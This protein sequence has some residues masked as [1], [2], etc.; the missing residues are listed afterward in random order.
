ML[1]LLD[2]Y[3]SFTWN[4]VHLLGTLSPDLDIAVHRN[5][6]LTIEAIETL[7]PQ[8]I[9]ISPGPCTP[10]ETGICR[11][12]IRTF[13]GCIPLLGV[14]LGHQSI[15]DVHGATVRRSDAPVH[16]RTSTINHTG[17]GVFAALPPQLEVARYHSLI[18]D[19]E[20]IKP[21]LEVT[22][23]TDDGVVMALRHTEMSAPLVGV[24]FHPES[25]LTPCG[26]AL[27]AN[28]LSIAGISVDASAIPCDA[29]ET[30]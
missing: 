18:V 20:A 30:N 10:S 8:A 1:L 6:A 23:W 4:L 9:V 3:D 25:F 29:S 22:A 28:F 5:D 24:Q 17:T 16:G 2:N 11:D 7:S 13:G 21:P 27:M 19:R 14:C 26:P 12:V 15:A